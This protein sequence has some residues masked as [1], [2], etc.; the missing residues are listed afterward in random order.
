MAE[1]QVPGRTTTITRLGLD[2]VIGDPNSTAPH[3]D[4]I[5]ELLKAKIK[6][7]NTNPIDRESAKKILAITYG[8]K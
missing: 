1:L 4:V 2:P 8:E 6:D 3:T 5:R 7:P